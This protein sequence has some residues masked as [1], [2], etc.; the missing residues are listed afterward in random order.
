[1]P[2]PRVPERGARPA[3]RHRTGLFLFGALVLLLFGIPLVSTC[4]QRSK[5]GSTE[6]AKRALEVKPGGLPSVIQVRAPEKKARKE[7]VQYM[8]SLEQEVFVD[9]REP[10]IWL[11][12]LMSAL[13]KQDLDPRAKVTLDTVVF[14]PNTEKEDHAL[15]KALLSEREAIR[16]EGQ[17]VEALPSNS[18]EKKTGADA[19][20][21]RQIK[22]TGEADKLL[23][24]RRNAAWDQA[25]KNWLERSCLVVDGRVFLDLNPQVDPYCGWD[26]YSGEKN[27][28]G[29]YDHSRYEALR[30]RIVLTQANKQQWLELLGGNGLASKPVGVSIAVVDLFE[31]GK[32]EIMRT[33]INP[34]FDTAEWQKVRLRAS[35]DWL[36]WL[37]LNCFFLL[38]LIFLYYAGATKVLRDLAPDGLWHLSLGRCQ[39]AFWFFI[40]TGSYIFLWIV[41]GDYRTLTSQELLLLGIS[42]VT[43]LGA[44]LISEK[45]DSAAP[46]PLGSDILTREEMEI[47]TAEE[48]QARLA[49]ES[50]KMAQLTG[51][52]ALRSRQRVA[53]FKRRAAYYKKGR[54]AAVWRSI[55]DLLSESNDGKPS[56]HRFQMIGWNLAFGVIFLRAVYYKLAM[57]EF[58]ADQLLLMGISNGTYL[59]F[60]WSVSRPDKDGR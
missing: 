54:I 50:E 23:M 29:E 3:S 58:S 18:T 11:G 55:N 37:L 56:F 40:V 8:L 17:R 42:S 27:S 24:G 14:D 30:F 28:K 39:M 48:L 9:V 2:E 57:P 35:T 36:T 51:Q 45:S 59:G 34:S 5:T 44:S 19:L 26:E 43:G 38:F 7:N 32:R 1:M 33:A 49:L 10:G 12:Q 4:E 16:A 31:T 15:H 25:V 47:E 52:E 22:L 21:Q 20:Q 41:T 46:R 13:G 60:K 6:A 53:E